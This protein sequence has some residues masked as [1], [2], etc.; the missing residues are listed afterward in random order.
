MDN[1]L[2][3]A[4]SWN[5]DSWVGLVYSRP[6]ATAAEYLPEYSRRFKTAEIDS[7]F[8]RMPTARDA[9]S[10][11]A[12]VDGGFRFTCKAPRELTTRRLPAP[13]PAR[14]GA[15]GSAVAAGDAGQAGAGGSD[16]AA[17]KA[18]PADS[19]KPNPSFLSAVP[20]R[21]FIE[22]IEPLHSRLDAV[23][24]EF[25]Y[26]NRTKMGS[27]E[28]FLGLLGGFA[29]S[30]PREV[31]IAVECRNGNYM[32]EGFFALLRE[33][34]LAP[35]LSEKQYMPSVVSLCDSFGAMF[36][37]L[38]VIRLMGGDRG[39]M[40]RATGE[41][42]DRIVEERPEKAA[43]ARMVKNLLVKGKRVVVNVNNHYEGS[44]PL[45]IESLE[46]MLGEG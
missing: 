23:I 13:G 7:W 39:E 5:Y 26:M 31:P 30:V 25:E 27:L 2:I 6:R 4:C 36:G 10:Y 16:R 32:K 20:Y 37:D 17:G 41:R 40:E 46:R 24:L 42:W 34:G 38:V 29:D 1:P 15:G 22:R 19:G 11:A 35:V 14:G 45:T 12:A 9:A 3:G 28:E 18:C 44:A 8:Y 43:I 33:K 21:S